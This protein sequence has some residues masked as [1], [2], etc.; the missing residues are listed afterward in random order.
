VSNFLNIILSILKA[1]VLTSLIV[2]VLYLIEINS[3]FKFF[4]KQFKWKKSVRNAEIHRNR[5]QVSYFILA[6]I[7]Y[8]YD[9][10]NNNLE[11]TFISFVIWVAILITLSTIF[12]K[13]YD[14]YQ[15]VEPNK[16]DDDFS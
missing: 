2:F 13:I 5:D 7:V 8:I 10:Y 15:G 1:N 9:I 12:G 14:K 3:D 16:A 11:F 6:I 4:V